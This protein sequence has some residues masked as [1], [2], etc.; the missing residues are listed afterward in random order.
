[1]KK[2]SI[3]FWMLVAANA[4]AQ[5]YYEDANASG[6]PLHLNKNGGLFGA[7]INTKD[8]SIKLNFFKFFDSNHIFKDPD[9]KEAFVEGGIVI[10]KKPAKPVLPEKISKWGAGISI[11]GKTEQ[12]FGSLFS[13]GVFAPGFEGGVYLARRTVN[14][15]S[16]PAHIGNSKKIAPFSTLLFAVQYSASSLRL[17]DDSRSFDKMKFDTAFNGFAVSLSWF[18]N[19][20][21]DKKFDDEGA[22]IGRVS[23]LLF[24]FSVSYT[25]KNNY[26]KLDQYEI[27]DYFVEVV[28][29]STGTTRLVQIADDDGYGYRKAA[30]K[31]L[32][33]LK[34]RPHVN[35]IPGLFNNRVG[36]IFYPSL[37][38]IEKEKPSSNLGLGI[39]LLEEGV[40]ALSNAA[41]SFELNDIGNTASVQDKSF[42]QRSFSV[43]IGASFF[44][45]TGKKR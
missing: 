41:I 6:F 1:M 44:M 5:D 37:D 20:A 26:T 30:Y 27:K 34:I 15:K 18:K 31:T 33:T 22:Y 28:D 7:R 25:R 42:I 9:E 39:H 13:S 29:Q 16:D 2:I 23:N 3:I 21:V 8:N 24:G 14:I 4:T 35:Y 43:T 36:I 12:E 45:F 38:L 17:Y 10:P 19:I 11:K 32:N 40:P